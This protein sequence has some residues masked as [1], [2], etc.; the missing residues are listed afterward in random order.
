M[1]NKIKSA[2]ITTAVSATMLLTGTTTA[3]DI[4]SNSDTTNNVPTVT[5]VVDINTDKL[6]LQQVS[7][8]GEIFTAT[9]Y[10]PTGSPM[11]NGEWPHEGAIAADP[12]YL[13]LGTSV[14]IEFPAGYEWLTGS[15]VVKDTGDLVYGNV[16]D[17]FLNAD[18]ATLNDL[19]CVTVTVY[20]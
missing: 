3:A 7:Y 19:G 8:G 4:S 5:A 10:G 6:P 2:V 20:R 13:P 12:S 11:A 17:I 9:F 14:W 15:Y 16:V 1:I 18:D